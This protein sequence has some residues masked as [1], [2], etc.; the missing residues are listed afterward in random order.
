MAG[1]LAAVGEL[2]TEGAVEED[3]SLP[4]GHAEF[5][6]AEGKHVDARFPR[7]FSGFHPEGC[8][9]VCKAGSIHVE[10]ES[11]S[12]ADVAEL[13]NFSRGVDCAEFGWTAEGQSFG[14]RKMDISPFGGDFLDGIWSKFTEGTG[15]GE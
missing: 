15:R 2:F 11:E 10:P 9:G 1:L 6:A 14:F 4:A 5:G 3:D 7:E 12:F 13:L 8:D